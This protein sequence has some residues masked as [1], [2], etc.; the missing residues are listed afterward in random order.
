MTSVVD[1]AYSWWKENNGFLGNE[2]DL[3]LQSVITAP[4]QQLSEGISPLFMG[5]MSLPAKYL[6]VVQAATL[7]ENLTDYVPEYSKE[8][9]VGFKHVTTHLEPIEDIHS[10]SGVTTAGLI[11]VEY[12]KI[13]L[14][15]RT[16]AGALLLM[17]V[18]AEARRH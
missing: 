13:V 6:A 10:L 11:N 18:S 3:M 1:Q 2:R 7:A 9:A 4:V 15:V 8:L 17:S 5:P 12:R 14:P 16:T